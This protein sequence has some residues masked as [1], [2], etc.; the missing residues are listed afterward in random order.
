[1]KIKNN[2]TKGIICILISG[3]GFS[4]M[5]LFVKLSGDLPAMQKSFFRN[6]IVTIVAFFPFIKNF[7][8]ISYPKIKFDWFILFLRVFFGTLGIVCNFYAISHI[9]LAD[10]T[11]IQR[12]YPFIV[13]FLSFIFFKENISKLGILAILL[14]FSGVL[15][16]IK[17][18]FDNILSI[19]SIMALCGAFCSGAA[20]TALR[21]LGIKGISPEFIVFAFSIFSCI[22]LIP[23]I[24]INFVPMTFYQLI[25]LILVGIFA[26]IGQFGITY[27]YKFAAAKS[28]AVF[29]YF[30]ILFSGILG[31]IFFT[32][33]PDV[34]SLFGYITIV[35]M[36][37][38]LAYK[39]DK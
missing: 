39:K 9:S 1:M 24:L 19:G 28:I 36:G 2:L 13:L 10:S 33:I 7:K 34:Y 12:L 32:E 6:F 5:A 30:Q 27:A 26:A 29:D 4:L 20:Y 31:Y 23:F 18:S 11:V 15:F 25:L 17:P 14:S 8:K 3:L 35:L 38:L 16:I 37:I 21:R 22:S